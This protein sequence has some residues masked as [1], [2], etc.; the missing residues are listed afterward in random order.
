MSAAPSHAPAAPA[1]VEWV[2][3]ARGIGILLVVAGHTLGGLRAAGIFA[4]TARLNFVIDWIYS[5]HM[6]LFFFL[7]GLFV[8]PAMRGTLAS[9]LNGKVRSVVYPYVVW[10]VL[11]T[12]VQRGIASATNRPVEAA[13]LLGIAYRPIMQF[14]FL[15]AL[16]LIFVLFGLLYRAGLRGPGI[17]AFAVALYVYPHVAPLGSWGVAYSVA[18]NMVYF[19][20]GV[21]VA[22]AVHGWIGA[23]APRHALAVAAAGC[24]LVT[25]AVWLGV[26]RTVIGKPLVAA[27]GIAATAFVAAAMSAANAPAVVHGWGL[28]SLQ[29]YV[30]HTIASA[31]FR[32]GLQRVVGVSDPFLHLVGGIAVGLYA[33]ILLNHVCERLGFRY[34]FTWPKG[35]GAALWH[36]LHG[37]APSR[38]GAQGR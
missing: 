34:A 6:P 14:W 35:G 1:R 19:A 3:Y 23:W 20:G 24:V 4:D 37:A 17:F 10:S 31:G 13:S 32:I 38:P 15:Y 36:R 30:A 11:Q 28:L 21:L 27:T 12:V 18:N 2:D 7:S 22:S 33:P 8:L 5:F 25:L 26:E 29:I 9:F 16:F